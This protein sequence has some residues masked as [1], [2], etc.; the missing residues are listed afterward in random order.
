MENEVLNP[1]STV[2]DLV[3]REAIEASVIKV[4]KTA[5]GFGLG[6]VATL[7]GCGIVKLIKRKFKGKKQEAEAIDAD[8]VELDEDEETEES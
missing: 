4:P 6:I 7:A 1:N 3:P 8:W 5:A 2:T